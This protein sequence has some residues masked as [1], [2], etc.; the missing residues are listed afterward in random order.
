MELPSASGDVMFELLLLG[1]QL[2]E[3]DPGVVAVLEK[4]KFAFFCFFFRASLSIRMFFER[5]A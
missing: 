3:D 1:G 5:R 2:D 4:V